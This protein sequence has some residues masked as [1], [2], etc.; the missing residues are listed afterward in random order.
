LIAG[1]QITVSTLG[2]CQTHR[3][4]SLDYNYIIAH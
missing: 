2:S 3:A 1:K 4:D